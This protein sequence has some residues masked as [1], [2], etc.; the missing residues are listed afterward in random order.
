MA[1]T[2]PMKCLRAL[3]A[4]CVGL[5]P[6]PA[7]TAAPAPSPQVLGMNCDGCHGPHG[8]SQPDSPIPGLAGL[9]ADYIASQMKAFR[10]GERPSTIMGRIAK[11]YTDADFAAIGQY[12]AS[13]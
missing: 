3:V 1:K 13:K 5:L 12:Y 2:C 11:G 4:T 7:F 6:L 9:P 10:S 8:K